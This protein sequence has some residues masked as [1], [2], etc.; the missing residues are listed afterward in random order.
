VGP[1]MAATPE[2]NFA[3]RLVNRLGNHSCL[4]DAATGY[5]IT[6]AELPGLISGFGQAFYNA[7]LRAGDRILIGCSLSPLSG[8]AYLGAMYAGLV[9]VPV[10]DRALTA[11]GPNLLEASGSRALWI[12]QNRNFDWLPK[13]SVLRLQ[14]DLTGG[15]PQAMPPAACRDSDLAAL[16]ATSGSTGVPRFVMISHGN[17]TANTEAIIRS[18][19]LADNERAMLILPLSYCFGAS[20][21][22]THLCQNGGIV[23]DRRFMFPDK[24]LQ[25]IQQYEC[26]TFA[27]V[28]T[29]YHV[30]LQRS[31]VRSLALP[32]L[33]RMLQAG[34][35]LAPRNIRDICGAVPS[36][37]FYA[38]Y[39][40]TE[41]TARISCLEPEKLEEKFGSVGRPLDN[42][43]VRI[44]TEQGH[45]VPA[46]QMG[47]I[48]VQGPSISGGY[49]ND[50]AQTGCVFKDGW[51]KTGDLAHQDAEGYL[52]IHGR[53]GAFLKMRGVRVS[54]GEA[55]AKAAEI[56]GVF[57]CVAAANAHPEAGEALVLHIV[58]ANGVKIS[59]DEV[60][61][62]LPAHWVIDS[63]Q[64]VEELPKNDHGKVSRWSLAK[65]PNSIDGAA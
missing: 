64:F 5:V 19:H 39:G 54:F 31:S 61:H 1:K 21:F 18:Q 16:M 47:E 3:G 65:Q 41:A 57:E 63:I 38:M 33:R 8:L 34:G 49:F 44:V 62:R 28:P 22:H 24:V 15:T 59:A 48:W 50:A 6:P 23:F 25:S 12:E 10:D 56:P 43:A 60:R 13:T 55:E 52:W 2:C 29:A 58:P 37:R 9:A 4:L 14:G 42:L 20:V 27:G 53:I 51:L 45:D 26:T 46:G 11:S 17:L 36:A 32:S 30:L 40:Q 7:G 35:S